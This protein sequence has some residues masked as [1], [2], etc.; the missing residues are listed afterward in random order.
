MKTLLSSLV[1]VAVLSMTLNRPL[2]AQGTET[3]NKLFY[4]EFAGPGVIMSANFDARFKSNDRLGLG[5]RLG[6]GFGYG[7]FDEKQKNQWGYYDRVTRTYYSIPAG[8]NYVFG[9]PDSPHTFEVGGGVTFLTRKVALYY[10]NEEKPGHAIGFITFM[11]RKV[12]VN[13]GYSW[14]IGLTPVIGTAG[15]LYPT[16]AI[17][18]GYAF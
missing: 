10:L 13:G 4:A 3:A 9:K 11:Y 6:V 1:V 15:D 2:S 14:R 16:G 5:Y 7:D 18:I 17:S 12:P 8:L